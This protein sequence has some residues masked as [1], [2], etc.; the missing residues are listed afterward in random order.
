METE[1]EPTSNEQ[2]VINDCPYR[3]KSIGFTLMIDYRQYNQYPVTCRDTLC[4]TSTLVTLISDI[5][6][7]RKSLLVTFPKTVD[8]LRIHRLVNA[9]ELVCGMRISRYMQ[10]SERKGLFGI[11]SDWFEA[12]WLLSSLSFLIR[13]AAR[14]NVQFQT[15]SNSIIEEIEDY[16]EKICVAHNQTTS[17]AYEYV[18]DM[19]HVG[20]VKTRLHKA[21]K[22]RDT[23]INAGFDINANPETHGMIGA[24]KHYEVHDWH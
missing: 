16:W 14:Y 7:K 24:L 23:L 21:L 20:T 13:I 17:T 8:H 15:G 10:V 1:K 18:P 11:E 22:S 12:A 19:D 2:I 6:S 5:P 4:R 9:Y 3:L